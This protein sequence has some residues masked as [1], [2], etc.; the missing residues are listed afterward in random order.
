MCRCNSTT[1]EL[2]MQEKV[3]VYLLLC[4][5]LLAHFLPLATYQ[6]SFLRPL[7]QI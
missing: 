1:L 6:L 2:V 4:L 3:S 7:P 5:S